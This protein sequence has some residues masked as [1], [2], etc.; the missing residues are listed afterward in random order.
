M[1][2]ATQQWICEACGHIYDEAEGDPDGGI[3]PGT[4]FQDIPDNWVC[5]VCGARKMDFSPLD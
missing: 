2:D 4:R 3:D 5:P 1:T